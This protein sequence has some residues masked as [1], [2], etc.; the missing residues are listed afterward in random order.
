MASY[1]K[2]C[3]K[4]YD[5]KWDKC[6]ECGALVTKV[7]NEKVTKK[8]EEQ[9]TYI[10]KTKLAVGNTRNDFANMKQTLEE[11]NATLEKLDR[12]NLSQMSNHLSWLA[13]SAQI[14]LVFLFISILIMIFTI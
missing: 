11:I 5:G 1:C 6:P 7:K 4:T 10:E 13:L 12:G 2:Y 9:S 14:G 3:D 8:S